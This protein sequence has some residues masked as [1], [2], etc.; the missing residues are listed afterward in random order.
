MMGSNGE[1]RLQRVSVNTFRIT[2]LNTILNFI[3]MIMSANILLSYSQAVASVCA[4]KK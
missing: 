1:L 4:P 2:E 3:P